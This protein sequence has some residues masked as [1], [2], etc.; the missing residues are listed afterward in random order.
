L[1]EIEAAYP[2]QF[3][4]QVVLIFEGSGGNSCAGAYR[5]V[6]VDS[7]GI[8]NVTDSFG[9]CDPGKSEYR[10]GK[11]YVTIEGDIWTYSSGKLIKTKK[12]N[13]TLNPDAQ[14]RRAG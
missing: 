5:I 9:G 11:L 1:I 12:P 8:K 2:S 6:E 4:A 3:D 14:K 10:N 13:K 7:T